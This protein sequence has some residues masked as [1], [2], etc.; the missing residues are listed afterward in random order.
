MKFFVFILILAACCTALA[1]RVANTINV[2]MGGNTYQE[3]VSDEQHF[4]ESDGIKY[5]KDKAAGFATYIRITRPG[6][7]SI[8]LK[9]S[10][11]AQKES[12]VKI[13]IGE[14][15]NN[16]KINGNETK[17][18]E[19]GD[20]TISDTG[21]IKIDLAAVSK[22][23]EIYGDISEYEISGEPIDEST[24]YVKNNEGNFFH[25]G[26]RGPSVHLTYPF[27]D[28]IKAKWFYSEILVPE[29]EDVI[30]SYF[31]TNGFA[32]GYFGIQVNSET[33]RRILFSV[34][35]P[36]TTDDP[37]SIPADMQIKMLKK[38]KN[39]YTGEFGN[40]GSG[41]QSYL[42]YSWKAGTTYKFLLGGQPDGKGNTTY[43]AYYFSPETNNWE[44]IASFLRP[45]TNTWLKHLHSFLENF[46]PEN[47]NKTREVLFGNQWLCTDKFRWI[48]LNKAQFTCDNTGA[49]GYRKD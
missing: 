33:E 8:K 35:S 10:V 30:G 2:P 31:M 14:K 12:V 1:F 39:V 20:W 44:L 19:A 41:G 25:W 7:L 18:Y 23:G 37:K 38:G 17:F 49:K 36:Y 34:W 47:G 26:R 32:E 15:S 21:Y 46:I 6:K 11:E 40:E 9:A 4:I 3:G 16:I 45:K 29:K 5:W 42:R 24:S 28:S 27:P 48:S 22:T 13:S 43:T